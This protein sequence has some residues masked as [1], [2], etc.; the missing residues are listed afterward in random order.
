M[1]NMLSRVDC[2]W[3]CA[4]TSHIS[5]QVGLV[6]KRFLLVELRSGLSK[7]PQQNKS[8]V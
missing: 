1:L 4:I 3:N 6:L 7:S 2:L 8:L 5:N